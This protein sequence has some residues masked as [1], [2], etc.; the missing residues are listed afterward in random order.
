MIF[1]LV[2]AEQT[3]HQS[4]NKSVCLQSNKIRLVFVLLEW[5][6]D[7]NINKVCKVL[8]LVSRLIE[9]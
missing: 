5:F 3:A 7:R 4:M 6:S 8:F 9:I 1:R 2:K